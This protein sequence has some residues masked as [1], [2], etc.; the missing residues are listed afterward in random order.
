MPGENA[1]QTHDAEWN[2]CTTAVQSLLKSHTNNEWMANTTTSVNLACCV[3]PEPCQVAHC[4][5]HVKFEKENKWFLS[6]PLCFCPLWL[7]RRGR[8]S[9]FGSQPA[10]YPRKCSCRGGTEQNIYNSFWNMA[11]FRGLCSRFTSWINIA[12]LEGVVCSSVPLLFALLSL[13]MYF[14]HH[15]P[16]SHLQRLRSQH[17]SE[18]LQTGRMKTTAVIHCS[19]CT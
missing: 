18:V 9:H 2:R 5:T 11:G 13:C 10:M 17:W 12:C 15:L 4:Y 19:C 3:Q 14:V 16:A 7:C 6:T 1:C 8:W